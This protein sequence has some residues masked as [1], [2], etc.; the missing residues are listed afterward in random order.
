MAIE[1]ATITKLTRWARRFL[2]PFDGTVSKVKAIRAVHRSANGKQSDVSVWEV[3]GIKDADWRNVAEEIISALQDDADGTGGVQSYI[4]TAHDEEGEQISRL[5]LRFAGDHDEDEDDVSS[6]P[7]TSK[8]MLTQFMRHNEAMMRTT[9]G[10]F[11]NILRAS[12]EQ[13]VSLSSLVEKCTA[14]QMEMTLRTEALISQAHHRDLEAKEQAAALDNKQMFIK[15][16]AA[17]LPVI[18]KKVTGVTMADALPPEVHELRG[19][20]EG[21]DE[22]QVD[23]IKQ[24]LSPQQS[25][26]LFSLMEKHEMDKNGTPQTKE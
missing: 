13:V 3:S 15:Q 26:V 20:L 21:L 2:F 6:E 24:V 1:Q 8:G 11:A 14:T 9:V 10:S 25:I 4:V 18:A 5:P 19:L 7:A 12:Q 22:S 16:I 23:T 17:L